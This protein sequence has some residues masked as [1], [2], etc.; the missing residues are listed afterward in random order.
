MR[1]R[2]PTGRLNVKHA[3]VLLTAGGAFFVA[4]LLMAVY[5]RLSAAPSPATQAAQAA[6]PAEPALPD[7]PPPG[8]PSEPARTPEPGRVPAA[9]AAAADPPAPIDAG[10]RG[11]ADTWAVE[12][13]PDATVRVFYRHVP[14]VVAAH[15]FWGP[16]WQW[17]ETL[18]KL[19][20]PEATAKRFSGTARAGKTELALDL[21][22]VV[23]PGPPNRLTYR[24]TVE[25]P[26]RYED[27]TGGGLEFRLAV[28]SPVFEHRGG[29]PTLLP[30][31]RGWQWDT[32]SGQVVRVEFSEPLAEVYFEK[33][34]R[35]IIRTF[36]VGSE[37][38]AGTH[39]FTMTVTLPEE[40]RVIPSLD[41]RYGPADVS[42]WYRDALLWNA[43]PVDLS[44]LNDK[45]AG[46]HGGVRV[47]GDQL[48][49]EDG[50][51]AR[52]WGANLAASALFV[53][54][55][56]INQQAKRIAELGYN[57]IRIHHHDSDWVKPNVFDPSVKDTRTLNPQALDR[58]DYWVSAL[59]DQGVYV[60]L[61]VHVGRMLKSGDGAGIE[62][63]D[64]IERKKGEMRGFCYF[65]PGVKGLMEEF[66]RKYLDRVNKYTGL[67]YKDD[68]VVMG[69][70]VTN[71]N[72]ITHHFGNLMLPDK[73]NPA[74]NAVF[75]KAVEA[76][77]DRTGLPKGTTWQTWLPGT[78]KIFLNDREYQFGRDMI[79]SL[80]G[81]G[82]KVP[83]ATTSLWGDNPLYSLPALTAG[84]LI[85]V[86]SYGGPESLSVNPRYAGNFISYIAAAQVVGKPLTVTEWNVPY[87]SRDRFT[88]PLYM[89]SIASLQGWD[90]LMLY[91]YSQQ[92]FER[93]KRA[94][95]WSTFFDPGIT[96]VAPAAAIAYRE[97]HIAPA[98]E[99]YCVALDRHAAYFDK[100]N[101]NTS[102]ALRTL[103]E[104]SRLTVALPDLPELDWDDALQPDK[105]A[106]KVT[107]LRRDFI[108]KGETS[109]RS[110][111]GELERNW[112]KGI[113]TINTART[114]AVSGWVGGEAIALADTRFD[115]DT[116][117]AV[118]AVTSLDG[119]P[120]AESRR[121]LVTAVARVIAKGNNMPFY[122]E[123][124]VGELRIKAPAG[125]TGT[126]LKA[127]GTKDSP[128]PATYNDGAYTIPLTPEI[129]THWLILE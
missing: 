108:P 43:S 21:S 72:D 89:A 20:N 3:V 106:K 83:V 107:D 30:D 121:I 7:A 18:V 67:A 26:R 61:D 52:F 88:A 12:V 126:P 79:A 39:E 85:D 115:L 100:V 11:D 9:V 90:A 69:L 22:G 10:T 55:L 118:V 65:N 56:E 50:T 101:A 124:V 84:D 33:G 110:D 66:Q 59:K 14:V 25:A 13:N 45:P 42:T 74:H 116:R 76:F 122:T 71:E 62:G 129:G 47:K 29:L 86:H 5:A 4:A 97:G 15:R 98:R 31:K 64:E 16:K 41:E 35:D 40:G 2:K 19:E 57:L 58:I 80:R 23:E 44:F 53:G 91:N 49:F 34:N 8:A 32:G 17:A 127:N 104:R 60:W 27:I 77:C 28:G 46:Q 63:F 75:K 117:K 37:L 68:P 36:F 1:T 120:I 73:N 96:A 103:A 111:T 48:V 87:P 6:S 93:P 70:L 109:V 123:P 102:A 94:A 38:D 51:P 99:T 105:H 112:V 54:K 114:Q 113:Q 119:Q 81:L 24:Y 78:S 95:S 92:G 125:L 82:F 128:V